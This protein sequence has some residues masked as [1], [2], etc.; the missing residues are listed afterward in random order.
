[1]LVVLWISLVTYAKGDNK[2][3]V[4]SD[5]HY[6][7]AYKD[8]FNSSTYCHSIQITQIAQQNLNVAPATTTDVQPLGRFLCD[9]PL[10]LISSSFEAMQKVE[11]DP[12][13][14]LILGDSIGHYTM[15][16]LNDQGYLDFD[17]NKRLVQESFYRIDEELTRYFPD[18]QIIY[19]IGNN[20][21]YT[22]YVIPTGRE[23]YEYLAFLYELWQPS[24]GYVSS[25]FYDG[26]YYSTLTRSGIRII[27]IN[28]NYYTIK[29][30][31]LEYMAVQQFEWLR[32]ELQSA[33]EVDEKVIIAM[34]IP[35]GISMFGSGTQDW[36][37]VYIE[38]FTSIIKDYESTIQLIMSGH[39]HSSTFQLIDNYS[40]DL[41]VHTSLS[42]IFRNNPAFRYYQIS[43]DREDYSDYFL[44]LFSE[45]PV[46]KVEYSYS[47]M[48]SYD[49]FEFRKIYEELL[50]D[51][52][53]LLDFI[54]KAH[55]LTRAFKDK[56]IDEAYIWKIATALNF[57]TQ[58][59]DVIRAALCSIRYVK[60]SDYEKC[61]KE[62]LGVDIYQDR[63]L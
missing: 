5:I 33:S 18:T 62:I 46:W 14:I 42:P 7:I 13:F 54:V 10:K 58:R 41:L 19:V 28:S 2:F 6:D 40:V 48:F 50:E 36:H 38:E 21:A 20:D 49:K 56:Q 55:G 24:I 53:L 27:A 57:H 12:E 61:F 32:T 35:P 16:L 17:Y 47:E 44:D 31:D 22:D 11:S 51:M 63:N 23:G 15:E 3:F 25:S 34:H 30:L 59:E 52:N 37:E 43:N 8:N 45:N 9:T 60:N 4:L 1:M 39:F 26:G 29:A